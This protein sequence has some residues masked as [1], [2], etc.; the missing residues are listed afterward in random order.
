MIMVEWIRKR[1]WIWL[2][3]LVLLFVLLDA[4]FMMIALL[5]RPETVG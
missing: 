5:N 3:V 2:V 1:P 4:V